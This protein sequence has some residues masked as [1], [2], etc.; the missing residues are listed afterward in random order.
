MLPS[1]ERYNEDG[2]RL[3]VA[4]VQK[5]PAHWATWRR[6]GSD[7]LSACAEQRTAV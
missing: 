6:S 1:R 2:L 5:I 7:Q 4:S 3:A